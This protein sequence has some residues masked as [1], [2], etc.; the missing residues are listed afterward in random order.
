MVTIIVAHICPNCRAWF[1]NWTMPGKPAKKVGRGALWQY[2]QTTLQNK[3]NDCGHL[4]VGEI[5]LAKDVL[6]GVKEVS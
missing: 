4:M 1:P 3:C 2:K 5:T 6:I